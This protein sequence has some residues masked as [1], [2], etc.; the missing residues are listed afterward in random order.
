MV[1]ALSEHPMPEKMGDITVLLRQWHEGDRTVENDLY[2]LVLPD[3]KKLA[4]NRLR[5]MRQG[6]PLQAT[7]LVNEAYCKLFRIRHLDWRSRAVFFA[8]AGRVMRRHLIDEIRKERR[9]KIEPISKFEYFL[10]AKSVDLDLMLTLDGLMDEL[11]ESHPEWCVAVEMKYVLGLTD[12]EAADAL[13][14]PERTLQRRWFEGRRWLFER[15]EHAA[16]N[17]KR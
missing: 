2:R 4:R 7:E 12:K 13:E 11:S 1:A 17:A 9:A 6:F 14:I 5:E 10:R 3:L 16:A 15:M 8:L